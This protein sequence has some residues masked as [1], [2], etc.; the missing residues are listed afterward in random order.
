MTRNFIDML[1]YGSTVVLLLLA[2]LILLVWSKKVWNKAKRDNNYSRG[3]MFI[4]MI[5][6][7]LLMIASVIPMFYAGSL[8]K[9]DNHCIAMFSQP[10]PDFVNKMSPAQLKERRLKEMAQSCPRSDYDDLAS[11]IK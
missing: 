10:Q 2:G 3:R 11:R 4:F 8:R 6:G 9:A 7:I 1:F 5:P